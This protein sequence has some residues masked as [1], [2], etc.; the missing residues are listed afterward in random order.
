MTKKLFV[1]KDQRI[2]EAQQL[3]RDIE[4]LVKEDASIREEIIDEYVYLLDD[5]RFEEMQE[6]VRQELEADF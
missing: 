5:K 1:P 6:F 3:C 4:Y 2:K